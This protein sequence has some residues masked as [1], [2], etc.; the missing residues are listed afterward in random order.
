MSDRLHSFQE[1]PYLNP[2]DTLYQVYVFI[3][4]T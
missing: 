4:I 1:E 3:H 2:I